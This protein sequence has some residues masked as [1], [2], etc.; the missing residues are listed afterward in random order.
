MWCELE[1]RAPSAVVKWGRRRVVA[2]KKGCWSRS[3][4]WRCVHPPTMACC[5]F[6]AGS[7][8]HVNGPEHS[9]SWEIKHVSRKGERKKQKGHKAVFEPRFIRLKEEH[10][11]S[12]SE[13]VCK[14]I[15]IILISACLL[16]NNQTCDESCD[17][18]DLLTELQLKGFTMKGYG[19]LLIGF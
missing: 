12:A 14:N 8:V 9:P 18:S 2:T 17:L 11:G 19:L 3:P 4:A 16:R 10:E 15:A 7:H 1:G 13:K 5:W 6:P